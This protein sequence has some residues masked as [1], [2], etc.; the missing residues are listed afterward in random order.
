MAAATKHVLVSVRSIGYNPFLTKQGS[1]SLLRIAFVHDPYD[2]HP[3]FQ[4]NDISE[5]MG[6][7]SIMRTRL[8]VTTL[9]G[10]D[11]LENY[12]RRRAMRRMRTK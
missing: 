7:L 3:R 6:V 5:F 10:V 2:P 1:A 9:L 11:F 12:G 4:L 8:I